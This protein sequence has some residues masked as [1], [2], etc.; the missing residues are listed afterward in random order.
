MKKL[1]GIVLAAAVTTFGIADAAHGF[2][3][4]DGIHYFSEQPHRLLFVA[5]IGIVGG[6]IAFGFS[7]LSPKL[8]RGVKLVLLGLGATFV[9]L[10]GGYLSFQFVNLP[11]QLDPS[12]PRHIPWLLALGTMGIA[13]VLL[14][15]FYQ[16]LRR[17]DFVS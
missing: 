6:L 10:G 3:S 2:I 7:A 16:V 5:V 13:G 12:I 1:V 17:R 8:Q 4:S 9:L 15:E 11:V 14:F